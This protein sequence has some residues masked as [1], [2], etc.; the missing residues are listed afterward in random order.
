MDHEIIE[1]KATI[2]HLV[3]KVDKLEENIAD[4]KQNEVMLHE[5][6]K[7]LEG[8]N[9]DPRPPAASFRQMESLLKT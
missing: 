4:L 9:E 2:V 1:M 7:A 5:R 3:R 8:S 6:L